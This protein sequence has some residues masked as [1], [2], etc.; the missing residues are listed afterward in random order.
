MQIIERTYLENLFDLLKVRG[1]DIFGPVVR[2]GVILYDQIDHAADMPI[3]WQDRQEKGT[4]RLVKAEDPTVFAYAAGPHS[5]KKFLHPPENLLWKAQR[6]ENG[7]EVIKN[8]RAEPKKRKAAFIGVR[9]CEMN[10]ILIQDK[11]FLKGQA[12]DTSYQSLREDV[13]I[14]AVNCTHPGGTCFCT[15]MGTGPKAKEGFD[16]SLTEIFQGDRHYFIAEAGSSKGEE[17]LREM[18]G[19]PALDN[20]IEAGEKVLEI[21]A[22]K[23]GRK[24]DTTNI[25]ELL[26]A[27]SDS[28]VWD[29]V[30]NRCLSCGNCTMVCPTCFC[31][32]VEDKTDLTGQHAERWSKWD[33][34]FSLDFSYIHGGQIRTTVKSRYRQW[35]THKLAAWIDQFGTS[36]CVGCGRCI[37]WC[38]V[39]IDITEELKAIRD[40]QTEQK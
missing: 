34:C 4:Y 24:L 15:S 8:D 14:V 32:T 23:M 6:T 33:S 1:Y 37:T 28:P 11:V 29:E 26:Y 3:G 7:F 36:G 19:Q 35:M 20:E 16:I 22:E 12:V 27:N 31:T 38:P 13:F 17:V 10:A 21:S 39:G 40:N 5:W 18:P 25:K 9:S 30:A 2:D